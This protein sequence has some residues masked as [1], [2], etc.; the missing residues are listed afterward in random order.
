M[1]EPIVFYA[2]IA[3]LQTA[4]TFAHDGGARIKLDIPETE[5][6][7]IKQLVDMRGKALI[8]TVQLFEQILTDDRESTRPEVN[9]RATGSPTR[10]ARRRVQRPTD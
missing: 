3:P 5:L 2:S 1:S 10:M 9:N 6:E 4:V 8:I 7:S